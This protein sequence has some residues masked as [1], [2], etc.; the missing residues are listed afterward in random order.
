MRSSTARK[1]LIG[2]GVFLAYGALLMFATGDPEAGR[3]AGSLV[4]VAVTVGGLL[5]AGR[6]FRQRPRQ[7]SVEADAERLGL[8]FSARDPFRLLDRGFELF[9]R[10]AP[11]R[12]LENVMWGSWRGIDV[13][14]F[15][16]W[17]ARSS[18]PSRDDYMRFSCVMT[19]VPE[20]WP[21]LLVRAE[22]P[23]TGLL[24]HV[25]SRDIG[26]ESE[27]FN[28]AF[29]VRGADRRFASALIERG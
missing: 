20:S 27:A 3:T 25:G 15:D 1:L 17:Y 28:D 19:P 29:E 6:W 8:R 22:G 5:L 16:Y 4:L 12:D 10:A 23:L 7:R 2:V 21:A 9:H 18:D 13:V 24:D 14:M 26:F 11:V